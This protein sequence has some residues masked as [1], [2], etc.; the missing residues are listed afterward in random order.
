VELLLSQININWRAVALHTPLLWARLRVMLQTPTEQL[1]TYLLRSGAMSLNI[2][3]DLGVENQ[4]GRSI[5]DLPHFLLPHVH[6]W[7]YLSLFSQSKRGLSA[8][9]EQISTVNA[10]QLQV[11]RIDQGFHTMHDHLQPPITHRIL[12]LGA[13][14]LALIHLRAVS[15][16]YCLPPLTQITSIHLYQLPRNMRPTFGEMHSVLSGLPNLFY[17]ICLPRE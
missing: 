12:T 2:H 6:R 14:I 8:F 13:P 9:L 15:L 5:A 16:H 7:H 10:S 17:F 3:I 1:A 4:C 11:F